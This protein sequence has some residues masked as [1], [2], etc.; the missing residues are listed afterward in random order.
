MAMRRNNRSIAA[1]F[2]ALGL[3]AVALLAG[4]SASSV[5][6][7]LPSDIG[8]PQGTPA[9]PA[10]APQYPAVHDMPAPRAAAPLSEEE[11]EKLQDDLIAARD[12]QEGRPAPGTYKPAKG[13]LRLPGGKPAANTQ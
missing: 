7:N 6:D 13:S 8:L 11:R 3:P 4:C 5:V 1:V 12:R 9:R 10:V 2:I